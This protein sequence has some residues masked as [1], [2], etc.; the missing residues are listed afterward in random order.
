MLL[1]PFSSE[2]GAKKI[3]PEM[4]EPPTVTGSTGLRISQKTN[5]CKKKARIRRC[6]LFAKDQPLQESCMI[7][8]TRLPWAKPWN[9]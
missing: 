1:T 6:V 9:L 7:W 4:G 2:S 3:T 5:K 8:M